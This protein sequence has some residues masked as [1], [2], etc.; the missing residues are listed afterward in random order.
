MT[1]LE[2]MKKAIE[3]NGYRWEIIDYGRHC[4]YI[5]LEIVGYKSGHR[6]ACFAFNKADGSFRLEE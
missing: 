3:F 5:V 4:E 1:D 6:L 2:K